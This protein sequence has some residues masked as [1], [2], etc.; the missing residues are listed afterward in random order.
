VYRLGLL[1]LRCEEIVN[2]TWRWGLPDD[3]LLVHGKGHRTRVVVPGTATTE[4]LARWRRSY[5]R[6]LGRAV[7]DSDPLLFA[8]QPGHGWREVRWGCPLTTT[9]TVRKI[10]G[11]RAE[12]AA[13]GHLAPHD[14]RRTCAQLLREARTPDGA[15]RFDLRDIQKVLGHASPETTERVYLNAADRDAQERAAAILD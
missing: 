4:L 5:E 7:I 10:V 15:P 13:L 12:A 14:L 3:S 1:G 11:R 2:A 6:K 9:W 8:G